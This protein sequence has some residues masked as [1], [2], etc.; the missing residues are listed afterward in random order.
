MGKTSLDHLIPMYVHSLRF[1]SFIICSYEKKSLSLSLITSMESISE[2]SSFVKTAF[3][4]S[5]P[6]FSP[7]EIPKTGVK[8]IS[9]D[10]ELAENNEVSIRMLP[11]TLL[12][13]SIECGNLMSFPGSSQE[14]CFLATGWPLYMLT[15]L[16]SNSMECFQLKL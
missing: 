13:S 11:A 3:V 10:L 14:A 5:N 7:V 8:N 16:K 2:P 15:L 12:S 1:Q 9:I 4:A 6:N